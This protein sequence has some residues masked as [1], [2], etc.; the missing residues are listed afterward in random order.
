MSLTNPPDLIRVR[1]LQSRLGAQG[2]V[3]IDKA[4]D[5]SRALVAWLDRTLGRLMTGWMVLCGLAGLAKVA[6]APLPAHSGQQALIMLAPFLLIAFAPWLAYRLTSFCLDAGLLTRQPAFRLAFLGRWRKLNA[7][8]VRQNPVFGPTGLMASLVLGLLVNIPLRVIEFLM[9][10]PAMASSAPSWGLV[11]FYALAA[12]SIVMSCAYM[13]CF[14][15]AVRA[16][17]LFPRMILLVWVLDIMMQFAIAHAVAGSAPVPDAVTRSLS[18]LLFG[19][20][21]KVLIST[22]VWL[23][24]ILLSDRVNVTYRARC[25]ARL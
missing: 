21:K 14:V 9:A 3:L 7:I 16:A 13:V 19:N 12:D 20:I 1:E 15:L 5:T 11:M 17:P 22:V 23:P 18:Y 4:A 24:Y 8:E 10:V 2:R 6:T 25:A